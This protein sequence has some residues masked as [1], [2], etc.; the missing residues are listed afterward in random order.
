M[1][2]EAING[3]SELTIFTPE[4]VTK[5]KL[6][7]IYHRLIAKYGEQHWW[8]AKSPFE[9]IIGAILTQSAAWTNV[10][11]A[12]VR[13]EADN[14][15]S[16]EALRDMPEFRLAELIR[17]SGYFNAKARKI[18]AF[19]GWLGEQYGGNLDKL[20]AN[21]MKLLR[22]QLLAVHGIGEETADSIILYAANKSIFVI[23]AYTRRII[24]RFGLRPEGRSYTDYQA[25]FTDNL[26]RDTQLFNEYH[27]LLV[28]LGKNVCRRRPLCGECCLDDI[29][30]HLHE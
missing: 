10:E 24:N 6:L 30:A 25:L 5:H 26:P 29:C 15:L 3:W 9:V 20:F 19:V 18:K 16:I 13:L 27:A 22:H 7:T 21:D 12:I 11:K 28:C 1:D 14:A 17:P 23:D 4:Q 8:P 2:Y